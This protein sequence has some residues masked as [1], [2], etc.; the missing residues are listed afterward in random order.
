MQDME[1]IKAEAE[2]VLFVTGGIRTQEQFDEYQQC[3][4]KLF[5]KLTEQI[6]SLLRNADFFSEAFYRDMN[7][8]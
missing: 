2:T 6:P 3:A 1:D 7:D 4:E 5:Q 8:E